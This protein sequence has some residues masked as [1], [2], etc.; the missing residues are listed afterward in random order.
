M[1][2]R[3]AWVEDLTD[4]INQLVEHQRTITDKLSDPKVAQ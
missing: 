2:L 4:A 1:E 3:Q